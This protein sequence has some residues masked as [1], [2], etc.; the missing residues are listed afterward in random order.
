MYNIA[1]T[2]VVVV[3]VMSLVDLDVVSQIIL[4]AVGVLWG[5]FFCSLAFV[6]P[7]LLE[8][9]KERKSREM[10][11]TSSSMWGFSYR[12]GDTNFGSGVN[13]MGSSHAN[14]SYKDSMNGSLSA[15]DPFV[16]IELNAGNSCHQIPENH[17]EKTD[18]VEYHTSSQNSTIDK[19]DE[20]P[21]SS[22]KC[23]RS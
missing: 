13:R 23:N 21:S 10:P 12:S 2:G 3:T 1:F 17:K 15:I 22:T 7:R 18:Q 20:E 19:T 9:N 14:L 6:L 16:E 8:V 4:Q 11:T 5:S